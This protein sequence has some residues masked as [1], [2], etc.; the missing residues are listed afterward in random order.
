MTE[1]HKPT[2]QSSSFIQH[3]QGDEKTTSGTPDAVPPRRSRKN[4]RGFLQKR[5]I[6]LLGIL[7]AML[8]Y[9]GYGLLVGNQSDILGLTRMWQAVQEKTSHVEGRILDLESTVTRNSAADLALPSLKE[10]LDAVEKRLDNQDRLSSLF[11]D[12]DD[13]FQTQKPLSDCIDAILIRLPLSS[14]LREPLAILHSFGQDSLWPVAAFRDNVMGGGFVA[15]D[16]SIPLKPETH[17]EFGLDYVSQNLR[18][19]LADNLK[20]T[21]APG[22]NHTHNQDFLDRIDRGDYGGAMGILSTLSD[23]YRQKLGPDFERQLRGH[24]AMAQIRYLAGYG[25]FGE[26]I[27][28]ETPPE[29]GDQSQ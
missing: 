19:F 18:S 7:A 15:A 29:T 1:D 17:G 13:R 9:Y 6:G 4:R 22:G 14:P 21:R 3:L 24:D 23:D 28:L 20:I 16:N 12:L 27:S 26:K 5:W 11:R 8:G 2:T 10:R 25:F